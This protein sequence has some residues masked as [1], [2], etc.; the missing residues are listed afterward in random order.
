M[1]AAAVVVALAG[2]VRA[3]T[4]DQDLLDKYQPGPLALGVVLLLGIAV[5]FLYRSMRSQLRRIDFDEKAP[6]DAGRMRRRDDD[7]PADGDRP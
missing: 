4:T 5:F 3:Q 6:D 7:G 2:S 1:S